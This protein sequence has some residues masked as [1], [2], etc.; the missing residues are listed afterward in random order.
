VAID[1]PAREPLYPPALR[2]RE[3]PSPHLG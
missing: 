1:L 3:Q 2:S